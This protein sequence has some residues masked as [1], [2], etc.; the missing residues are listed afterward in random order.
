MSISIWILKRAYDFLL[1]LNNIYCLCS[2]NFFYTILYQSSFLRTSIPLTIKWS[3]DFIFSF[4]LNSVTIRFLYSTIKS[5]CRSYPNSYFLW[6]IGSI[7]LKLSSW[8]VCGQPF[9][10]QHREITGSL[11]TF[12]TSLRIY[13]CSFLTSLVGFPH[14]NQVPLVLSWFISKEKTKNRLLFQLNA[15]VFYFSSIKINKVYKVY[16]DFFSLYINFS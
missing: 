9:F 3:F 15:L 11:E 16:A 14:L 5:P 13:T 8:R 12:P 4:S 1:R 2:S 6:M 10:I 7:K